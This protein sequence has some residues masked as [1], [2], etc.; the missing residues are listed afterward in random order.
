MAP[1][2]FLV[3]VRHGYHL[4]QHSPWPLGVGV[5]SFALVIGF[6]NFFHGKGILLLCFSSLALLLAVSGWWMDVTVEGTYLGRHT[7]LVYRG[8]R[9]GMLVFILSELMFFFSFFWSYLYYAS[10]VGSV[11]PPAGVYPINPFGVPFLNTLIL[12][13]SGFMLTWSQSCLSSGRRGEALVRLALTILMA[14]AFTLLQVNEFFES[15]FSIIDSNYGR[16]FFAMTG[17]HGL[18]VIV[19]TLFLVVN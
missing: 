11:W 16:I 10:V 19:G 5:G 9:I 12:V 6:V 17:F 8:L 3:V 13:G 14:F 18:H 15:T 2:V 7:S 4:V 1:G